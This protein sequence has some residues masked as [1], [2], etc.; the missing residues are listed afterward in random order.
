MARRIPNYGQPGNIA[1]TRRIPNYGQQPVMTAA[2]R[3]AVGRRVPRY[4]AAQSFNADT[5]PVTATAPVEPTP[6]RVPRYGPLEETD[7]Q[8]PSTAERENLLHPNGNGLES[9][10]QPPGFA[11]M[12]LQSALTS[13]VEDENGRFRSGLNM[14]AE[15]LARG[16]QSGSVPYA[17]GSGLMGFV[18][19]LIHP[20]QDE[21]VKQERRIPKLKAAADLETQQ[22]KSA[23][24]EADAASERG[25]R[26]AQRKWYEARPDLEAQK[27]ADVAA[28]RERQA[29][30]ANLRLLKNQKLDV[31]NPH[32][33][34]LLHRA[35]DAG[36][37]V[38]PDAWNEAVTAGRSVFFDDIDPANPTVKRRVTLERGQTTAAPVTDNG[39]PAQTGFVT[40]VHADTQMT[41]PQEDASKD[42]KAGQAETHRHNTVA[43]GQGERR[44]GQG[45][46][47]INIA[48]DNQAL[49]GLPTATATNARL[50]RAADLARRLE[51]EKNRAS[52]P[53][54]FNPATKEPMTAEQQ[55]AYTERHKAA[56]AGYAEQ[57]KSAYGDLYEVG[58]QNG[59]HY[60]KPKIQPNA[61]AP[62]GAATYTEDDVRKRARAAG[63]DENAA[64]D[65]ARKA[66]LIP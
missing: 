12:A 23:R 52:H 48:R 10:K 21:E 45:D 54:R 63:K 32:H 14:G 25:L 16:A 37:E 1:T 62:R 4:T 55:A 47:H 57:I 58:E 9:D 2:P 46:K 27:R 30:L 31:N 7:Q 43:E 22:A 5:P 11:Q 24:D 33:A 36:Y 38:D 19:G 60:A 41:A 35:A 44:I 6:R 50:A 64:V 42:R 65:A 3:K 56:A 17:L 34:A 29:V 15:G 61:G 13:P 40:P 8:M 18:S 66:G 20:S 51:D 39:Q 49:R 26:D 28:Q 53:P 59:W